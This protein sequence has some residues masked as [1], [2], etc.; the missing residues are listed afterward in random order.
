MSGS[1]EMNALLTQMRDLKGIATQDVKPTQSLDVSNNDGPQFSNMFKDALD[2][3]NNLQT[4]AGTLKDAYIRGDS[5][6]DITRV[7]V[8]SQKSSIAFQAVVQVRNKLVDSYKDIMN[9]PV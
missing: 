3:V 6:V 7:M 8:A 1:I 9:M 5:S 2:T 4:D